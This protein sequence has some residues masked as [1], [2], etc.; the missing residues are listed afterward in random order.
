[1]KSIKIIFVIALCF[2]GMSKAQVTFAAGNI[3]PVEKYSQFMNIDLDNNGTNDFINWS[4]TNGGATVGDSTVTGNIWGETTGWINLN[5]T[6]GGVT[7][8]CSGILGGTAWGQNTGW[9]NFAPT[10]AIGANQPKIN[11]TTGAITGTVWSQN[12]GWI[13]LSSPDG[14]NSGLI[15]SWNGCAGGGDVCT[16]LIGIQT[17]VPVGYVLADGGRCII[18]INTGG[19]RDLCLNIPNIQSSVPDGYYKVPSDPDVP[20]NC[21][22]PGGSND[23]CPNIPGIQTSVPAGLTL[24]NGQCIA[25]VVDGDLCV[26]LVGNQTTVPI[27]Y[28]RDA[29]GY[30]YQTDI[31]DMC[32][33]I[34]GIQSTVPVG[35]TRDGNGN[36]SLTSGSVTDVCPNLVGVQTSV[37][38][39]YTLFNGACA[40][41][42]TVTDVC[43][44]IPG[45][46][47][48][49]PNG[50]QVDI[51][52]YCLLP[53]QIPYDACPNLPGNQP[54]GTICTPI[55]INPDPTNPTIPTGP[56]GGTHICSDGIDNDNDGH[57]DYPDDPG[58]VSSVD[59]SENNP[60]TLTNP[61]T[62]IFSG[63]TSNNNLSTLAYILG[64]LGLLG[65]IPGLIPRIGNLLLA[66]PFFRRNRPYGI[67]F[68]SETKEPL[69]PVY[70]T[71]YDVDT[72]KTV[73]TKIT[74]INGRYGFLLPKGNYRMEAGKTHYQF[75]S[76]KLL[77]QNS[78]GVYDH[79]Y[80]G[81]VFAVTDDSRS[82]V[83]VLN[84]P[85]DRLADDWNQAEKKRM[86][87]FRIFTHNTKLWSRISMIIFIIGFIFSVYVLAISPNIWNIIV[88]ALY[89][90][91]AIMQLTGNGPVH[92]G[93]VTD[94][95][96]KG[97]PF[98]VVRVWSA[99]LG[100]Q[101][102]QRVTDIHGQ[103]Y[104]LITKGDYYITVDVK[105]AAG[106]YDRVLT[107]ETIKVKRGIINKDFTI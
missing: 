78:D 106:G 103:Y 48:S 68:D 43:P 86:G 12:Y 11:T 85:M 15:T 75:P 1:M 62:T 76:Q 63:T 7:N 61:F 10:N 39:G 24:H 95:S 81:E 92:S 55:P 91:F 102:A 88:F 65:T 6:N 52:G 44:N 18:P 64:I 37:P 82:A 42:P 2:F 87:I 29:A 3:D 101:I 17:S 13:Q 60:L 51:N 40:M 80:F 36:C 23:V 35:Y 90:I 58:C 33:N 69:D 73:D 50:Y 83:I 4:P 71:V 46:Q 93:T 49:V 26:N 32:L 22:L 45:N 72:N 41:S 107:S 19:S 30:C 38:V 9:I 74:D 94:A 5:P 16:N 53:T 70:V 59:D 89:V 34:T 47:T 99:H 79:L 20:G 14:T 66:I 57:I 100:T 77:H 56:T 84:I 105:N 27:G 97:I 96:G 54:V 67:V 104:L 21:Y 28:I 98:A 31:I 25:T 8:T